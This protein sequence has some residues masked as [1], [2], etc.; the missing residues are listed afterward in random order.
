MQKNDWGSGKV[1]GRLMLTG[2][3]YSGDRSKRYVEVICDCGVIKWVRFDTLKGSNNQSCGCAEVDRMKENNYH[4]THGLNGHPLWNVYRAIKDRCYRD[5]SNRSGN[6]KEKG[7]V[8]CDE[9]L[10]S[11]PSFYDWAINNGWEKGLQIDKDILYKKKYGTATG[12][13]YSPEFCCFVTAKENNRNRTT[14]RFLEYNGQRKTMAEWAEIIGISQSTLSIRLNKYGWTV[15][16]ALTQPLK[17]L[18]KRL[19]L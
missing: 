11:Y 2:K 16:R 7:V 14:S 19:T 9:W 15:E 4:R 8:M 18:K 13:I 17:I 10:N 3:S 6:Y 1:F 12:K 5:S